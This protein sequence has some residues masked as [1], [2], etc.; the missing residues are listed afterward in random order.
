[1][2][3][4]WDPLNAT[5]FHSKP[6]L[7]KYGRTAAG[8]TQFITS[9]RLRE[10]FKSKDGFAVPFALYLSPVIPQDFNSSFQVKYYTRPKRD[11]FS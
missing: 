9:H 10:R 2:S 3:S 4:S 1:M 8:I 7:S 6:A 11:I 5:F